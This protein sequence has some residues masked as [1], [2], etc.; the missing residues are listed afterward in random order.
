M[1][2]VWDE[3]QRIAGVSLTLYNTTVSNILFSHKRKKQKVVLEY[4][5]SSPMRTNKCTTDKVRL[6]DEKRNEVKCGRNCKM[7]YIMQ[8]DELSRLE[9]VL[10]WNLSMLVCA[11]CQEAIC[12]G[13]RNVD[14][15]RHM[16]GNEVE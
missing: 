1:Q 8:P 15:D 9:K 7:C 14:Y 4:R 2:S 12:T 16:N 13:C 5:C 3:T 11:Q 10:N 6:K